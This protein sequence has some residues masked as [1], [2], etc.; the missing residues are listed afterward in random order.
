MDLL[1]LAERENTL[2]GREFL[3][4]LWYKSEVQDGVF[5]AKDGTSFGLR[6]EKS[7]AVRGGEGENAASATVSGPGGELTEA[8]TGLLTGKTVDK[9]VLHLSIDSNDWELKLSAQDFGLGGMKTPKVEMETGDGV[10]P[11]ALFLE[12]VYLIEKALELV[13]QAY[14]QFLALRLS[15]QWPGE[16]RGFRAWIKAE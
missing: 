14:A 10:D 7:V 6:M 8:R 13:D 2:L 15:P 11:D 9:A 16:V 1:L 5:K 12:K 4:W 3:T